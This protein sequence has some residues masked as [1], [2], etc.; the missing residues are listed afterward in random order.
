MRRTREPLRFRSIITGITVL[1]GMLLVIVV[2]IVRS[3]V[4]PTDPITSIILGSLPNFGA[5]IA[6]PFVVTSMTMLIKR[7]FKLIRVQFYLLC[8]G[9]FILIVLWE[10]VQLWVWDYPIDWNDVAATGFGV[11][12]AALIGSWGQRKRNEVQL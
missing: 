6:L 12:V 4:K 3:Y 5:G 10:W 2:R 11:I 8:T 9:V 1:S 7:N